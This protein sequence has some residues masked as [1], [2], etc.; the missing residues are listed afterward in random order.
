MKKLIKILLLPIVFGMV[1]VCAVAQENDSEKEKGDLY[2]VSETTVKPENRDAFMEFLKAYKKIAD[3]KSGPDYGVVLADGAFR[4]PG[5]IGK[6]IS[7]LGEHFKKWDEWNKNAD[8]KALIDKYGYTEEY[9]SGVIWRYAPDL[10]YSSEG[11]ETDVDRNYRRYTEYYVKADKVEEFSKI[12]KEYIQEYKKIG[13]DEE[14]SSLW[15]VMGRE[16]PC[17]MIV[18]SYED[19]GAW[20]AS[21]KKHEVLTKDNETIKALAKRF[22]A[23]LRKYESYE[24]YYRKDLSHYNEEEKK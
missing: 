11:A 8:I 12:I 20:V 21:D 9:Y 15:N 24:G 3:E 5:N 22:R 16:A 19:E 10:S 7:G 14:I 18:S 6:E 13:V 1:Q 2:F 4:F 23:A 17:I